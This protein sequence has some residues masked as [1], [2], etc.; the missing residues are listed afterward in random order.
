MYFIKSNLSVT[1]NITFSGNLNGNIPLPQISSNSGNILIINDGLY[2]PKSEPYTQGI[3]INITSN[4]VSANISQEPN[5]YLSNNNGL[6][7]DI[8]QH[9]IWL[10]D[11]T[12]V[13]Y[14]NISFSIN[15]TP[16]NLIS[17]LKVLTP[18]SGILDKFFNT[19][20]NKLNVYNENSTL[21]F[22]LALTGAWQTGTQN[23]GMQLNFTSTNGNNLNTTRN[24]AATTDIITFSVFFSI[25]ENGNLVS[26]GT[27]MMIHTFG[28]S[29]NVTSLLVIAEQMHH[30]DSS[31]SVK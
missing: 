10:R 25:D 18:T 28:S 19:S 4:V 29:F 16:T 22:K 31:I 21:F 24:P 13:F 20:S 17:L 1:G 23:L 6:Y 3:G 5:N 11:K 30:P 27:D 2:V 7:A 26:N 8:P 15:S 12:E 9:Y 14:N